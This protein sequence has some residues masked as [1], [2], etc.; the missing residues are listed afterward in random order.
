ME[1]IVHKALQRLAQLVAADRCSMFICRARNGTP[2]VATRLFNITATS[3]FEE[4]LVAPDNEIVFPLDIGLVG[5]VAHTKKLFNVP[6]VK[7]VS[8][9]LVLGPGSLFLC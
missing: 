2:E 6:D 8:E 1:K 9:C 5:W 3:K 7:K 4:N